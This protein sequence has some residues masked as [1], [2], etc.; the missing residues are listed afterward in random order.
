VNESATL[1]RIRLLIA[2]FIVELILSGA[3]A[4][5]LGIEAR[6]LDR[7][8][9]GT[10]WPMARLLLFLTTG[11]NRASAGLTDTYTRYSF[12]A[13]RTDWLAFGHLTI[14]V[15]LWGPYRDPV[16]NVWV[17][18]FE[19]IA[20]AGIITDADLYT[21]VRYPDVVDGGSQPGRRY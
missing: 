18:T 20:C 5:P 14:A 2:E 4:F 8:L 12:I 16:R 19:L 17:L 13:Y 9:H 6:A 11:I 7:F 1:R 15:S 3:T 10:G 21:A